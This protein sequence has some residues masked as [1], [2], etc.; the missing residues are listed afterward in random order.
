MIG[1]I[2]SDQIIQSFGWRGSFL[3]LG[4]I[5]AQRIPLCLFFRTPKTLTSKSN[6]ASGVGQ[7]RL[8]GNVILRYLKE[9]FNF[10]IFRHARYSVYCTACLLQLFC[11]SGYLPHTVNRAAHVGLTRHQGVI[12]T[13][14]ISISSSV[15]RATVSFIANL[16][17]VKSTLV[18]AVGMFFAFLSIVVIFINP[19]LVGTMTSA[20]M[21][22][23]HLGKN[24][25]P[26]EIRLMLEHD[27]RCN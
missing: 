4:A 25:K 13:T 6:H 26:F 9:T 7:R 12:A 22:G 8:Y 10:S 14:L 21:F 15:T 2:L 11:L 3:V 18:F 20:A 17:K 16:P 1:S 27:A 24:M 5:Q 23:M 19:G